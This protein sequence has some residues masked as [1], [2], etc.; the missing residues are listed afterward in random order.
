[1]D[2][3]IK[4]L[5]G[6]VAVIG[7]IFLMIILGTLMGGIA[8]WTVGVVFTDTM[9]SL[10]EILGVTVSDFQFGAMFGFVGGFFRGSSSSSS[11]T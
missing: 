2:I 6:S 4:V 10:K 11:S 3:F 5:G 8:G 7:G 1:M 9:A